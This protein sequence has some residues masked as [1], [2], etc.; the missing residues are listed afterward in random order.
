MYALP[1]G[2][3]TM[4]SGPLRGVALMALPETSSPGASP[5][6]AVKEISRIKEAAMGRNLLEVPFIFPLLLISQEMGIDVRSDNAMI[7]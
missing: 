5:H 1:S 6:A 7:T 2:V 3:S 4:P